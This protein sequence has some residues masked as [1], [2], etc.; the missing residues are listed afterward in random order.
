MRDHT[1]WL[2]TSFLRSSDWMKTARLHVKSGQ[3]PYCCSLRLF[4]VLI[5]QQE[6]LL[7]VSRPSEVV[8]VLFFL[9]PPALKLPSCSSVRSNVMRLSA[10]HGFCFK[11]QAT[12]NFG[13]R[14]PARI[15]LR[16]AKVR[17]VTFWFN[18]WSQTKV[19][20][21]CLFMNKR[22]NLTE[23][24]LFYSLIKLPSRTI[25]QL[26]IGQLNSC[27]D[28]R[29]CR[30]SGPFHL[31]VNYKRHDQARW[32]R[33]LTLSNLYSVWGT[34]QRKTRSPTEP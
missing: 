27:G 30:W 33:I 15:L 10:A 29:S 9:C 7:R 5:W 20:K 26:P 21:Q 13:A 17:N 28:K 4:D 18:R 23:F 25:W 6:R 32:L 34:W 8:S 22:I 16:S 12:N 19:S 2:P 31:L 3:R 11:F 24:T 1:F 14:S